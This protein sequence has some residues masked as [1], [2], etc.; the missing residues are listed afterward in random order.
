MLTL[1]SLALRAGPG[2]VPVAN[3]RRVCA[4]GVGQ[5][6]DARL[7]VVLVAD[8]RRGVAVGVGQAVHA[9]R[10]RLV[11]NVQHGVGAVAA[12]GALGIGAVAYSNAQYKKGCE[13]MNFL[14]KRLPILD[15]MY[16]GQ[17][18]DGTP[19]RSTRATIVRKI[20]L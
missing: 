3:G 8:G 18:N 14:N 19:V 4:V 11:A 20:V 1:V 15:Q 10:V 16:F 7:V 5:A 2:V 13:I 9:H 17:S 6:L 12:S